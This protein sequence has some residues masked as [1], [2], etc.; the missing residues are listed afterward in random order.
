VTDSAA[1]SVP[2]ARVKAVNIKT[3]ETREILT[4]SS[5]TY[6]INNLFPGVYTLEIEAVGFAKYRKE[7]VELAA[8]ENA[9]VDV[10]LQIA[11]QATSVTVDAQRRAESWIRWL[12]LGAC[13]FPKALQRPGQNV[14]LRLL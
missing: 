3:N 7:M 9:R 10:S 2:H 4:N 14:L 5:G 6:E 12:L 13:V 11:T 8:N 1:A